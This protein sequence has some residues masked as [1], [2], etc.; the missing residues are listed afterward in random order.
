MAGPEVLQEAIHYIGVPYDFGEMNALGPEGGAGAE[1]DCSGLV[2]LCYEA[3][4]VHLPHNAE[5]IRNDPQ[6][7]LY[8]EAAKVQPG[9][10]VLYHTGSQNLPEGQADH[11]A[12]LVDQDTQ[13]AAPGTGRFVERES[14]NQSALLAFAFV[15]AVTGSH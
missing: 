11:C 1:V 2:C 4:D 7:E 13:I 5:R 9:D 8:H 6:I 15:E 14:V 12:I 3:V 10:I